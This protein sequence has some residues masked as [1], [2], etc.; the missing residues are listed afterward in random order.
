MPTGRWILLIH[1]IPPRPDYLR[2]KVRRRLR[3]VGAVAIKNS[4]YALPA[5]EAAIEDFQ[6]ILREV[7]SAGGDASICEAGFVDGL[8]DAQVQELFERERKSDYDALLADVQ[9]LRAELGDESDRRSNELAV[10][11]AALLRRQESLARLDFF[12]APERSAVASAIAELQQSLHDPLSD[13]GLQQEMAIVP[14]GGIWVTRAGIKVD[15]IASAWLI[16][17]FLDPD[18]TF[19]FV[20]ADAYAQQPGELRFDMFDGEFTHEGDL[21]TFEV[22]LQRFLSGDSALRRIADSVHD[23]DVKDGRYGRPETAGIGL[24]IEGIAAAHANDDTRLRVGSELLDAIYARCRTLP[25]EGTERQPAKRTNVTK[26]TTK[27]RAANK[28]RRS[29]R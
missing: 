22:L 5:G 23:L 11:V 2:V 28:R 29:T 12:G 3:D 18:A 9:A 25:S 15:R 13:R 7:K 14:R 21:C 24:L 10:K 6:W 20:D 26:P 27:K 19:R 1:Q 17:R 4:V 16:R 8:S